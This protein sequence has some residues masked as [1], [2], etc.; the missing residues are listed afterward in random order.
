ME[1]EQRTPECP[2]CRRLGQKNAALKARLAAVE[3]QLADLQRRLD[4]QQG[5]ERRQATPF[6]RRHQ[7]AKPKRPGRAKDHAAAQRARPEHVD[8]V[9]EVPLEVCPT[10]QTRLEDKAVHEQLQIDIPPIHPQVTQFNIHSGY[11]PRCQRRVQGRDPRQTSA[12]VGA[13]GT[14]I[15]PG[16]LSMGAEL[17]HRLGVPYRKICDFLATYLGVEL[18]AA[19]LV[20][21]EQ[22]LVAMAL[23]SYQLL[24]EAVR[25]CHVVHADETG[26][27]IERVNAWLWVFSAQTVTVYVIETSRGHEVPEALLGPEFE[28]VLVVDGLQSYDVLAYQKGR[29][30]GHVLR[31]TSHLVETLTGLDQ[32]YVEELQ[33][34]LREAVALAKRREHLTEA[35]YWRRVRQLEERLDVWLTW[36]GAAPGEAVQRLARHVA[37]H[38]EEWFRF[39]YD[40]EVPATNNHAERM[41]RPAVIC[42]K[43]GGCNKNWLGAVVHGVLASLAVSCKQQGKRF[44]DLAVALFRSPMPRA[45]PLEGLPDG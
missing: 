7:Q 12:A 6:R 29:C 42:R 14:Q 19:T 5:A 22:R 33:G 35:G 44:M 20:R 38:R 26:W 39:L 17:K 2:G 8:Q 25:R 40:P 16:L 31:R 30:V 41:L 3:R 11:C 36:H 21:A 28:G 9:V 45:I 24:I 34:V 32:Y 1:I 15:G 23:P 18:C 10:C 4:E 27:R 37:A 13:A 43:I